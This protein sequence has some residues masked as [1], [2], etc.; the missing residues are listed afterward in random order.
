MSGTALDINQAVIANAKVTLLNERT[1]ETRRI[2]TSEEGK[3]QFGSLE[4]G[5]Y[6]LVVESPG[7]VGYRKKNLKIESDESLELEITLQVGS[8]GG[9]AFLPDK[10]S[11]HTQV[12]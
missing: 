5:S 1:N 3:F 2:N 12:A 8:V 6:T 7:F 10:H 4:D 9:A 11:S